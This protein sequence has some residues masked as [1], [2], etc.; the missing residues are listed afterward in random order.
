MLHA[1][2]DYAHIQDLSGKIPENEPVMLFR[3]QD[4][5]APALLEVYADQVEEAQGDP[6][7][8]SAVR[9]QAAR[10]RE[11]QSTKVKKSPDMLQENILVGK[12]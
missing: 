10:M 1:R 7:I 9:R 12:G 3:G 4:R 6:S 11:W 8:V 5:H 2:K